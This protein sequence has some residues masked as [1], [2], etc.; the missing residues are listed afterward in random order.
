MG[1]FIISK[2]LFSHIFPQKQVARI[3]NKPTPMSVFLS[4]GCVLLLE[5]CLTSLFNFQNFISVPP[6]GLPTKWLSMPSKGI[7]EQIH[8][9]KRMEK[10]SSSESI[11]PQ[12]I[13]QNINKNNYSWVQQTK[14]RARVINLREQGGALWNAAKQIDYHLS[15]NLCKLLFSCNR[16][17]IT[18]VGPLLTCCN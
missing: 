4:G 17:K 3:S 18:M 1:A 2:C 5:I 6:P 15:K 14:C 10:F 11:F 12:H 13:F 7:K 16:K 9:F 8:F